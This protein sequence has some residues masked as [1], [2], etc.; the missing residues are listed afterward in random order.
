MARHPI[1]A[2]FLFGAV[3]LALFLK[4]V[5]NPPAM[6]YDE[7]FYVLAAKSYLIDG[8]NSNP[9]AP[10]LGKLL[11]AMAINFAVTVLVSLVTPGPSERSV[12]A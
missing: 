8:P 11:I 9:E 12:R 5:S 10:P 2:A 4:G 1:F 6:S 7:G 3:A